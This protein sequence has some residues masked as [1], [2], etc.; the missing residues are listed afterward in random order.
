V[1]SFLIFQEI[2]RNRMSG[3]ELH[4]KALLI[5]PVTK[6]YVSVGD[7]LHGRPT[8]VAKLSHQLSL[9]GH[10]TNPLVKSGDKDALPH[11][12]RPRPSLP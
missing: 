1:P 8:E 7:D 6:F 5:P 2:S 9:R 11:T 12:I 10:N 4:L 3:Q